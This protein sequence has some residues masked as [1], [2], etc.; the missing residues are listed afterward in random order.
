MKQFF[1]P[2][3]VETLVSKDADVALQPREGPL[4]VMFC[5]IRGFSRKVGQA[6]DELTL[7]LGRVSEALSVMTRSILKFEGVIADFQ[8]DAALGF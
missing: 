5:D 3:V 4:S 8:G 7:L 6:R 1:S 2:A